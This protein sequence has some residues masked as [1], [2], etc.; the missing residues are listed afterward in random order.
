MMYDDDALLIN[1]SKLDVAAFGVLYQTYVD[2]IF[3]FLYYHT[4]DYQLAEDLTAS[5]FESALKKLDHYTDYGHG[6]KAWLYKIA[7][8]HLRQHYRRQRILQMIPFSTQ[9]HVQMVSQDLQPQ[10][11]VRDALAQLSH[12]DQEIIRLRYFDDLSVDQ[13]SQ[14]LKCLKGTFYVRLHRALARLRAVLTKE[15]THVQSY[16]QFIDES[17]PSLSPES[18]ERIWASLA[19]HHAAQQQKRRGFSSEQQRVASIVVV[20]LLVSMGIFGGF[21]AS[22]TFAQEIMASMGHR[23]ELNAAPGIPTPAPLSSI[24]TDVAVALEEAQSHAPFQ[25]MQ[26][27][28]LPDGYTLTDIKVAT[29][30]VEG[31]IIKFVYRGQ[32]WIQLS[33]SKPS[34]QLIIRTS[35]SHIIEVIDIDGAEAI[36]Y[37]K[38][39]VLS[40]VLQWTDGNYWHELTG[41]VPLDEFV[42]IA[43]SLR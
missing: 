22:Y 25:L 5:T 42:K 20:A 34:Q 36:F 39:G 19:K 37:D 32:G 30:D 8:N 23:I 17:I 14:L 27:S 21:Q 12:R 16:Q 18:K 29:S 41:S 40:Q 33:Q 13:A 10:T 6:I 35:E 24:Q 1:Q 43:Q 31:T 26:P 9:A 28:Y 7:L 11:G 38:G 4:Y 2:R 3:R 15:M